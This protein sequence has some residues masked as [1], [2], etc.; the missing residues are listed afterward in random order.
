[1]SIKSQIKTI[2]NKLTL[3]NNEDIP[4][5]EKVDIYKDALN[6]ITKLKKKIDENKQT[7]ETFQPNEL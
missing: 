1:M 6:S 2:E 7:L 4:F 5:E 3:L